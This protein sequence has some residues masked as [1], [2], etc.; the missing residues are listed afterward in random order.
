[1][2]Y[3]FFFV[4]IVDFDYNIS[5]PVIAVF[6]FRSSGGDRLFAACSPLAARDHKACVPPRGASIVVAAVFC[7]RG[8]IFSLV[9][10][11]VKVFHLSV[12]SVH[13]FGGEGVNTWWRTLAI[14][15]FACGVKSRRDEK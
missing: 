4:S 6:W 1:M 15:R 10:H 5:P 13:A 2:G 11:T 9:N 7:F 12:V 8:R 3:L 14:P